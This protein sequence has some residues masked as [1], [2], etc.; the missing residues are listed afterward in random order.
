MN[1][2]FD[3][4][5]PN[6]ATLDIFDELEPS[7]EGDIFDQITPSKPKISTLGIIKKSLQQAPMS[8]AQSIGGI[9]RA[10]GDIT[11]IESVKQYGED[12]Y[13]GAEI[14]LEK[15]RPEME[16]ALQKGIYGATQSVAQNMPGLAL[17]AV[18]GSPVPALLAAGVLSG[19]KEYG[20]AREA[21]VSPAKAGTG[22][23]GTAISEVATGYIPL[24][25]LLQPGLSLAKRMLF[26]TISELVGENIN[27]VAQKAIQ[28]WERNPDK[29][30]GEFV[31]ELYPD[32]KQTSLQVLLSSPVMALGGQVLTK[33]TPTTKATTTEPII[34][35]KVPTQPKDIFD[36]LQPEEQLQEAPSEI[37]YRGEIAPEQGTFGEKK[38]IQRMQDVDTVIPNMGLENRIK[39]WRGR[40]LEY[41]NKLK[42]MQ[43]EYVKVKNDKNIS[44]DQRSY[45][46]SQIKQTKYNYQ[47][48]IRKYE[49]IMKEVEEKRKYQEV[50][51]SNKDI[52]FASPNQEIAKAYAM[53]IERKPGI[54]FPRPQGYNPSVITIE[55][56]LDNIKDLTKYSDN[57][58]IL[59]FSNYLK[60]MKDEFGIGRP[61]AEKVLETIDMVGDSDSILIYRLLRGDAIKYLKPFIN[62]Q[63]IDAIKYLEGGINYAIFNKSKVKEIK[64]ERLLK[65]PKDIIDELEPSKPE[66][67]LQK[68]QIEVA[69]A[70]EGEVKAGSLAFG[71]DLPKYTSSINLNNWD[72]TYDVKKLTS[73]IVEKSGI[74]KTKKT[75]EQIRQEAEE[76]GMTEKQLVKKKNIP[77]D[78]MSAEITAMRDIAVNTVQ[79][80]RYV[81][82]KAL[83]IATDETRSQDIRDE[84]LTVALLKMSKAGTV[85]KQV[86]G[87]S[88]EIGRALSAHRMKVDAYKATKNYK[89]MLDAL[90]GREVG[91]EILKKF[92]GIDPNDTKATVQ[93]IRDIQNAKTMD[94]VYEAWR[95]AILS[96]PKTI[97]TNA[98][99][100][101]I[102]IMTKPIESLTAASLEAGKQ[103][104]TGKPRKVFFGEVKAEVVGAI[105]GVKEGFRVGLQ[106]FVT[107]LPSDTET[108]I[109]M[110]KGTAIPGKTGR[111]IRYPQRLLMATDEMFKA[112][113]YRSEL[114]SLAYRKASLEGKRGQER[115]DAMTE[116]LLNPTEEMI[117]KSRNESLYRTYNKPLGKFGNQVMQLRESDPSGVL[118]YILPFIR[119]PVNIFKFGL[120]RTP[121]NFARLGYLI[122]KGKI[123]DDMAEELSK[124]LL[125]SAIGMG[126]VALVA[127]GFITGGAP[128]EK[129][130]KDALYRT[131][132]QPYSFK[133]GDTYIPYNRIEPMGSIVG[134]VADYVELFKDKK[135][136]EIDEMV[137]RIAT[138]IAKNW[139]NKTFLLGLSNAINAIQDPERYGENLIQSF[140]GS[141][142]PNIVATTVKATDETLRQPRTVLEAMK[143]RIPYLD[144]GVLP[145]QDIWGRDIQK[146]GKG[147]IGKVYRGMSP[148]VI[149][150]ASKDPVDIEMV[151]LLQ[152]VDLAISL[153]QEKIQGIK[154]P[155][156]LYREYVQ[157]SGELAYKLI[158]GAIATPEY[159]K[160]Q[161][162]EIKYKVIRNTID[163]A[164]DAYKPVIINKIFE[165]PKYKHL[166]PKTLNLK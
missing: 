127:Q 4:L 48:A 82:D 77:I 78:K 113:M 141:L 39:I 144:R 20:E 46:V 17:S 62:K 11:G 72:T 97:I 153:P 9:A 37:L 81:M 103:V 38:N 49:D 33:L 150:E 12:V 159:Q 131:G 7:S 91:L 87:T 94:M 120:E 56:K 138:S 50:V 119:T 154:L 27:T 28:W 30:T 152:S 52:T 128:K 142:V 137:G 99:S 40:V 80:T 134:S 130:K 109:E 3:T 104:I 86:S 163:K 21:G 158:S 84:A 2:I 121:I 45:F 83:K 66:E 118:K 116:Y 54:L 156:E 68:A 60:L 107:E 18:T 89:A 106:S 110:A 64:R 44:F 36:E 132:W 42:S 25:Y 125:G 129:E 10:V 16:T 161:D 105:Q 136:Q 31:S 76:I 135:P 79:Q 101:T 151:R 147:I 65:P 74:Q 111:I 67:Q 51:E 61:I 95:N 164:R 148:V 143:T 59:S 26:S 58:G 114:N 117:K 35:E 115:I 32:A 139:T 100:N 146:F 92:A 14:E 1:D 13:K 123:N 53:Q 145:R 149:S 126:I 8:M 98:I 96:S 90:G 93:F 23:A 112:I 166:I 160:L 47:D 124:P 19:G 63:N 6:T 155:P 41:K 88:S 57:N 140:A 133:I 122:S 34:E 108:K 70:S 55:S 75:F 43:E 69:P 22:A 162:D 24:G 102:T 5:T 29:T 71:M 165:T 85:L 73:D 15:E 157:K